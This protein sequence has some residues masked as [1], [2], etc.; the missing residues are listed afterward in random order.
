MKFKIGGLKEPGNLDKERV[1]IQILEDGNVGKLMVATTTQQA[2][3]RV[4]SKIN[5]PYWIPDQDVVKGDLII[6]YTKDGKKNSRKNE[7]GSSSYFFYIGMEQPLYTESN[8]TAV[9]FD[10]SNWTFARRVE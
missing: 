5:N 6:I 10:I 2:E 8:E 1:V 4:S 7:D 9:V 3:D